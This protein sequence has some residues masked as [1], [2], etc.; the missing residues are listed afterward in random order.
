[1]LKFDF[2]NKFKHEKKTDGNTENTEKPISNLAA[3]KEKAENLKTGMI[4]SIL[5]GGVT[6]DEDKTVTFADLNAVDAELRPNI[7]EVPESKT[8]ESLET[9]LQEQLISKL[10]TQQLKPLVPKKPEIKKSSKTISPESEKISKF[11]SVIESSEEK[12]II[13]SIIMDQ[14]KISYPLLSQIGEESDNLD[15]LEKLASPNFDILERFVYERLMV[16]NE[17]PESMSTSV[18]INCPHCD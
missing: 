8:A 5:K 2:K 13:P 18:R 11:I 7:A 9:K 17:H 3:E 4:T 16:C 10:E 12:M 6:G 15:F 1:M 14:G